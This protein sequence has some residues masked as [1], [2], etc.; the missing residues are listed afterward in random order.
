MEETIE[1]LDR[2][3]IALEK[4]VEFTRAERD[5]VRTAH[6]VSVRLWLASNVSDEGTVDEAPSTILPEGKGLTV[7]Q[8]ALVILHEAG[9]EGMTS[10]D[11]LDAVRSRFFPDLARTSLSPPLSR[12][13]ARGETELVGD[14]WKVVIEKGLPDDLLGSPLDSDA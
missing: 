7:G 1:L 8:A 14:R 11:I 4:E 3:I 12:L 10:G 2:R 6:K 13:K 9:P 5:E